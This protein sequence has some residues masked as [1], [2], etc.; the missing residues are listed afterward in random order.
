MVWPLPI[1][2][3][4]LGDPTRSIKTPVSIAVRV[5]EAHKPTHHDKVNGTVNAMLFV[6]CDIY[7]TN[8]RKTDLETVGLTKDRHVT[9]RKATATYIFLCDFESVS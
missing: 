9:G 3:S 8:S 2:L 5:N 6:F 1:D 4:G 7:L